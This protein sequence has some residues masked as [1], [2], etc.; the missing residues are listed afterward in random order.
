MREKIDII[1]HLE[2]DL[3]EE[4]TV[5]QGLPKNPECTIFEELLNAITLGDQLTSKI[6]FN[7]AKNQ[8]SII[9]S[10]QISS[11]LK[12][13]ENISEKDTNDTIKG[14]LK[15]QGSPFKE[16]SKIRDI[17]SF[18]FID[19]NFKRYILIR[20]TKK[21]SELF[22][23]NFEDFIG[24]EN[25]KKGSIIQSDDLSFSGKYSLKKINASDPNG[26][27]KIIPNP[28]ELGIMFSGYIYRPSN[29]AGGL[30]DRIALEDSYFNGYGFLVN[31]NTNQ[32]F[33][34][35]R[36]KG[37]AEQIGSYKKCTLPKDE[38]YQFK[39]YMKKRGVFD[40]FLYDA[41]GFELSKIVGISD[42]RYKSFDRIVIHG[43]HPYYLDALKISY[44]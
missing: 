15:M 26:G 18:S 10:K 4:K 13:E 25:Y 16:R 33:V 24:W 23:D 11:L 17:L 27:Y 35:R 39:F 36:N 2:G 38:W 5:F 12:A 41:S 7:I 28:I 9:S 29:S 42:T 21:K 22:Y 34:E 43:G 32:V 6:L 31:H 14:I 1:L 20:N 19:P 37:D 40:L 44:L 3:E 30:G 8:K